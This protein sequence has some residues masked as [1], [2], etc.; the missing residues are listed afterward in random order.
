MLEEIYTTYGTDDLIKKRSRINAF[1]SDAM[2]STEKLEGLIAKY[3][4]EDL[5]EALAAEDRKGRVLNIW[6]DQS[7]CG[8]TGDLASRQDCCQ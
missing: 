1:T 4:D 6:I 8:E 5:L 3:F 7:R 2:Y